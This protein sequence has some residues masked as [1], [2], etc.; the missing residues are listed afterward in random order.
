MIA[1]R[2]VPISIG[3]D[4]GGSLRFP[5]FFTGIYGLKPSTYRISKRGLMIARKI[6]FKEDSHIL[7]TPGP[8]GSSVEDLIVGMKV[9]S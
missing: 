9:M 1:A 3:T 7:A 6:R 2:C 8:M 4:E 5:T